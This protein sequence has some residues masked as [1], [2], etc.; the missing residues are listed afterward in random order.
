MLLLTAITACTPSVP[1]TE[2]GGTEI[3]E[4]K[5]NYALIGG[6]FSL[7]PNGEWLFSTNY[8][9]G[10]HQTTQPIDH[11]FLY[12]FSEA[13]RY[14]VRFSNEATTLLEKEG[15]VAESGCW[16]QSR[17]FVPTAFRRSIVLDTR[18]GPPFEW[19]AHGERPCQRDYA[20]DSNAV[21]LVRQN[22]GGIELRTRQGQLIRAFS[23]IPVIGTDIVISEIH[24]STD[25]RWLTWS[26]KRPTGSVAGNTA[27]W[28]VDLQQDPLAP[29]LLASPAGT[30]RFAV[31]STKVLA[32]TR[33][34]AED[35]AWVIA[36]WELIES[37]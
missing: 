22:D 6:A 35:R 36:A 26:V 30:V 14:P 16:Q 34:P 24:L 21:S 37:D 9:P 33:S 27:A 1:F 32:Q 4:T 19:Q 15:L 28:L 7:S 17:L 25:R 29:R 20:D 31:D 11:A 8:D 12:S 2:T 23:P 3:P 10:T 18:T 13:S 5:S